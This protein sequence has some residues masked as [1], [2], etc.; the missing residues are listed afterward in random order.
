MYFLNIVDLS[1][2]A[3][4]PELHSVLELATDSELYELERILFGP[5]WSALHIPLSFPR[6]K[7]WFG[8]VEFFM[9]A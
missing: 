4:D 3:F 5:R 8:F 7:V 2:G 9:T 6:N 1:S